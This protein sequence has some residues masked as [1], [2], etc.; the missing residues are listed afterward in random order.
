MDLFGILRW[1]DEITDNKVPDSPH[2]M[3][4]ISDEQIYLRKSATSNL[5]G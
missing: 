4:D 5:P 1:P 2:F 3:R